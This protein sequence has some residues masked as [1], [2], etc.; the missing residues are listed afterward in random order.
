M[1]LGP[2][3]MREE[4][5]GGPVG[6]GDGAQSRGDGHCSCV[7]LQGERKSGER[8][9]HWEWGFSRAG[10]PLSTLCA[11]RR[12]E[13]GHGEGTVGHWVLPELPSL[14]GRLHGCAALSEGVP[15]GSGDV[16]FGACG[17][18]FRCACGCVLIAIS[19]WKGFPPT[20]FCVFGIA[21]Q[22]SELMEFC[23]LPE[24]GAAYRAA[25]RFPFLLGSLV[26]PARGTHKG[27][28]P[29]EGTSFGKEGTVHQQQQL[30]WSFRCT[31]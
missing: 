2:S 28:S 7:E 8:V 19:P 23:H 21:L 27:A 25:P 26:C 22:L 9:L 12:A 20:G 29:P 16:A 11:R 4:R 30:E 13:A 10:V 3:D 17:C 15:K 14:R 5:L 31:E 18:A 24:P 6:G 1:R